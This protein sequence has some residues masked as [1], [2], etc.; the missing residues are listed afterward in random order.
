M[1]TKTIRAAQAIAFV[2]IS[3][4]ATAQPYNQPNDRSDEQINAGPVK[5]AHIQFNVQQ[6]ESSNLK[7]NVTIVNPFSKSATI[8]VY[9]GRDILYIEDGVKGQYKTVFNFSELEDGNYKIVVTSGKETITKD[10]NIHTETTTDRQVE[11]N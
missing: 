3:V 8:I 5:P 2:L 10:V 11:I 4:A 6:Q 9:K 1:F 7:F